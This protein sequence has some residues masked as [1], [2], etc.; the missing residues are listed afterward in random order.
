MGS[1]KS[2]AARHQRI[3]E[4]LSRNTVRT[5]DELRETLLS[6]GFEVTQAT[7]S[8]DLDELNAVKVNVNGNSIY[9]II[10]DGDP[11]RTPQIAPDAD[12]SARLGRVAAE[13][14]TGVDAAMNIVV[15]H[16]RAGAA[17]YLAGSIDKN[18]MPHVIGSVAGDDTVLV[19]TPSVESAAQ[20]RDLIA[21][22]VSERAVR[23][24]AKPK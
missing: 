23:K 3:I 10:E 12:A 22:L 13:V 6:E 19:V 5:Q 14:V 4:T 20:V 15:I 24:S 9:A 17:H 7:L 21:G 8:R 18:A 16:T 1:V 2:K 11:S